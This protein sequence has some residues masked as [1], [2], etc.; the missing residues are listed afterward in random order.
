[1]Y[2]NWLSL[3]KSGFVEGLRRIVLMHSSDR[4]SSRGPYRA[5]GNVLSPFLY[6]PMLN[7]GR[8]TLLTSRSTMP[9]M[10]SDAL[11]SLR[12]ASSTSLGH[13]LLSLMLLIRMQSFGVGVRGM[14]K[15]VPRG[16]YDAGMSS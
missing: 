1:M 7:A 12:T 14:V 6:T 5:T 8:D 4:S 10:D 3:P 13:P 16:M 9:R 11:A 2:M 15:Y